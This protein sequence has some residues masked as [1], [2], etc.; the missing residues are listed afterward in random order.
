MCIRDRNEAI[1]KMTLLLRQAIENEEKIQKE[2]QL[3][4]VD[5]VISHQRLNYLTPPI[6]LLPAKEETDEN[7]FSITQLYVIAEALKSISNSSLQIES[8]QVLDYFQRLLAYNRSSNELPEIW[9]ELRSEDFNI[10]VKIL[11]KNERGFIKWRSIC[12]YICLLQTPILDGENYESYRQALF[13]VSDGK[14][15]VSYTKF[16]EVECWFD[17]TEQCEHD[18]R[19]HKFDRVKILKELLFYINKRPGTD[20]LNINEYLNNLS[21]RE[22]FSHDKYVPS[23]YHE[24]LFSEEDVYN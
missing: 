21:G 4:Y 16:V 17:I 3:N 15:M 24:L 19:N 7:R 18:A 5:V 22:Y 1:D 8:N 20:K 13:S 12:T 14:D 10:M 9:R 11:D 6:K 23:N 2:H